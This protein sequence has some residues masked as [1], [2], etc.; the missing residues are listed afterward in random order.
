MGKYIKPVIFMLL[1]AMAC[2]Y[3]VIDA[4]RAERETTMAQGETVAT[5]A[6]MSYNEKVSLLSRLIQAEAEAEPY[7]GKVAVGAV[8]MN[9]VNNSQFPNTLSGVIY[10]SGAFE[11]VSNGRIWAINP[12][13]ETTKAAQ[14]AMNG[15][16]PTYGAIYFWN[17]YKPVNKW[18]W[19]RTITVQYYNHI[20][21]R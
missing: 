18:M 15:W 1:F 11:S 3:V 9:R 8:L 19:T 14:A 17:P 20:F 7:I 10:Q 12:T 16:D 13:S 5:A 21:A 2:T 6:T 4:G